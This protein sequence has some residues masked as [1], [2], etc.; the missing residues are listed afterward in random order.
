MK[1][2]FSYKAECIKTLVQ[3]LPAR[4]SQAT[5]WIT[6]FVGPSQPFVGK[7]MG[8]LI[9]VHPNEPASRSAYFLGF[10]ERETT[11]WALNFV[12]KNKPTTI[13]DVGAN[14]GYFSYLC[15][16]KN[17]QAQIHAFEPDPYNF[18]W[19]CRNINLTAN[20]NN[21][22]TNQKAVSNSTGKVS[23]APSTAEMGNNLWSQ[24]KFD[25]ASNDK[26]IEVTS[27]SLDEYCQENSISQVDLVKIDIEGAEGYAL[28]GMKEG[29]K[30]QLYKHVLL[31]V[32][33]Y[34]LSEAHSPLNL[35]KM[36]SEN[37]YRVFR[38]Q[39]SFHEK[40]V[41]KKRETYNLTWDE[42]FLKSV[43]LEKDLTSW[44]HFLFVAGK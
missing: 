35:V 19:L 33:P 43:D 15:L 20:R 24:I 25:E 2:S 44:E 42:S 14:F 23:F 16:A 36:F 41:D 28:E 17:P 10:Y 29:I 3:L 9:E 37:G 39:Q 11:L 22:V 27:T 6:R 4:R 38:F 8:N 21:F 7:F 5:N 13:F 34:Q 12:E 30:N 31:E 40:N 26:T 1:P 32:H 18:E